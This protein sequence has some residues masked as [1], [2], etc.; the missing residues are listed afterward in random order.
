MLI[1]I[2]QMRAPPW[3]MYTKDE[4]EQSNTSS[5]NVVITLLTEDGTDVRE[6]GQIVAETER[7]KQK[8]NH[9]RAPPWPI[10]GTNPTH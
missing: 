10:L 6:N 3:L 9:R 2:N 5:S 4:F 7:L 8:T 1:L